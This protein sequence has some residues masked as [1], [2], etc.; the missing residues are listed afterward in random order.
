[1]KRIYW[2]VFNVLYK[3][4]HWKEYKEDKVAFKRKKIRQFLCFV[5]S[6][7]GI[8]IFVVNIINK[9]KNENKNKLLRECF[10]KNK[11]WKT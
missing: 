1:M 7:L 3:E 6:S 2:I 11:T 10:I 4:N 8:F 5:K 9:K